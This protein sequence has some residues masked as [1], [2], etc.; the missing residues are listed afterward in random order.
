[1]AR[2]TPPATPGPT[3]QQQLEAVLESIQRVM[4]QM[5]QVDPAGPGFASCIRQ[6]RALTEDLDAVHAAALNS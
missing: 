6:M 1:M 2:R 5:R 3:P 4:M